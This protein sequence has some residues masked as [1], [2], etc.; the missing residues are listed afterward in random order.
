MD[1]DAQKYFDAYMDGISEIYG[2]DMEIDN[3]VKI[4]YCYLKFMKYHKLN[5]DKKFKIYNK[6]D[7]ESIKYL[8]KKIREKVKRERENGFYYGK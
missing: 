2:K 8:K 5:M 6:K 3:I 7:K 1:R 4:L